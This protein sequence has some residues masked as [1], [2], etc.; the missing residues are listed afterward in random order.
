MGINIKR[1]INSI[2][3][4]NTYLVWGDETQECLLIDCGDTDNLL[5]DVNEM[6]IKIVAILLTHAHFDHIY[7]V[8]R[9]LQVFPNVKVYTN[10]HGYDCLLSEK[11]NMSKYHDEPFVINDDKAIRIITEGDFFS[12]GMNLNVI[13]TPGH[14]PSCISYYTDD[15]IFTG[16]SYIPDVKVVTNLPRCNKEQAMKSLEKILELCENR[17]IYPGHGDIITNI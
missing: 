17:I 8:N 3:S 13:C 5:A 12:S 4:S 1:Y 2:Y 10:T 16:D 9:I 15:I 7:G 14:N 11:L 6:R